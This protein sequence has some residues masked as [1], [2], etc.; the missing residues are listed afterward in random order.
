MTGGAQTRSSLALR[1]K[2]LQDSVAE[3]VR[4]RPNCPAALCPNS[5]EFGY[6]TLHGLLDAACRSYSLVRLSSAHARLLRREAAAPG[7]GQP[8]QAAQPMARR[9]A[10]RAQ[11]GAAR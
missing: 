1:V 6:K 8:D 5:H 4:I 3:F 9:G 2:M 11:R 10:D 7:D